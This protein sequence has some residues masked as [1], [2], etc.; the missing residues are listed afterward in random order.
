MLKV[1]FRKS[2]I[3]TM[4][5]IVAFGTGSGPALSGLE[6]RELEVSGKDSLARQS[7]AMIVADMRKTVAALKQLEQTFGEKDPSGYVVYHPEET[8]Q[9]VQLYW[10]LQTGV[11]YLREGVVD[12]HPQWAGYLLDDSKAVMPYRAE[13]VQQALIDLEGEIPAVFL[14]D[15]RIFLTPFALSGISGMGGVGFSLIFPLP[16]S[17]EPGEDDLRVTLYHELGHH[18]HLRYMPE[19]TDWGKELWAEYH[20]FRGGAWQKAG[21][22]GTEAWNASSE[23]TFAEDF[24]M[25]FGTDQPFFG[26]MDLGDPRTKAGVVGAFKAFVEELPE[27][28]LGRVDYHSPWIPAKINFWMIQEYLIGL[29]WLTLGG[30]LAFYQRATRGRI[31]SKSPPITTTI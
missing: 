11:N 8:A 12:E 29:L 16:E 17:F 19:D 27:R 21:A 20:D 9:L 14:K 5:I 24:R 25:V 15:Y 6:A 2:W 28:S 1:N 22:A 13:Q 10:K 26:D 18:V 7:K 3:W 30:T 31:F 4:L 23:E